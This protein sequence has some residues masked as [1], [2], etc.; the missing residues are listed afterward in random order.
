LGAAFAV[1]LLL[2]QPTPAAT[3]SWR[4]AAEP[5]DAAEAAVREAALND[6]AALALGNVAQQLA[7]TPA[8]GLARLAAG[9]EW[10]DAAR[11]AEALAELRH[12]DIDK[13]LL[14]DH[15][16]PRG[17]SSLRGTRQSSRRQPG[18]RR[19]RRSRAAPSC[20]TG[21]K[22]PRSSWIAW[23]RKTWRSRPSSVSSRSAGSRR[24]APCSSSSCAIW[25]AASARR[26]RP[27]ST[28][29]ITSTP[30]RRRRSR[31]ACAS[32][33]SRARS[34]RAPP[35]SAHACCSSAAR[36]CSPRGA[37]AR[38]SIRCAPCRSRA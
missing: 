29:S 22:E 5:R 30:S 13:I 9:L 4:L 36:R 32:R 31:P 3:P 28:A 2:A 10:L 27:R 14:R 11:P 6:N 16:W 38:R 24:Q 18:A 8:G 26:P 1:L 17:L 15:A 19:R 25:P 34:R 37:P 21:C 20:A 33:G 35:P 23:V 7:G 12:Q